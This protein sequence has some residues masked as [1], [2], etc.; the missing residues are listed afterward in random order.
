MT[1]KISNTSGDKG[2]LIPALGVVWAQLIGSRIILYWRN[3]TRY[4]FLH[5]AAPHLR[6]RENISVPF[7][8]TK[9]GIRDIPKLELDQTQLP[10]TELGM[11]ALS[12]SQPLT[13]DDLLE[14]SD[15]PGR[16]KRKFIEG[17][18]S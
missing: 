6:S 15:E 11:M 8:I 18:E 1:T 12:S 9:E 3:E 13:S 14:N 17:D 4:A 2:V 10:P 5:K 7:S 16:P